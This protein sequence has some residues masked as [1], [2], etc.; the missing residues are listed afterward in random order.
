MG[1]DRRSLVMT[2]TTPLI[3]RE[4]G[5]DH[6]GSEFTDDIH[7]LCEYFLLVPK[8]KSLLM[9][10]RKP[11]VVRRREKLLPFI[12]SSGRQ[13]FMRT[14]QSQVHTQIRTDKILPPFTPR[15]GQITCPVF[16]FLRQPCYQSGILVVWMCRKI[17]D[18]AQ[19]VE[20]VK[21]NLDI[22]GIPLLLLTRQ[23]LEK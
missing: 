22:P 4:A 23:I 19:C 15:Q 20:L 12:D 18:C 14:Y 17:Q 21:M 8:R 1:Q 3:R 9:C 10:L 5:N 2:M 6:I 11:K 13:Q 7:R 16:F